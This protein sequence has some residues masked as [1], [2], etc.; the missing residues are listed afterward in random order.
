M[1]TLV[2]AQFSCYECSVK[3]QEITVRVIGKIWGFTRGK[4]PKGWEIADETEMVFYD[5]KGNEA[6]DIIG[7]KGTIWCLCPECVKDKRS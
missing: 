6:A 4:R 7:R 5:E 2:K 3:S 1:N